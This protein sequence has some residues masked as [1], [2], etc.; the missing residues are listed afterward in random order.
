MRFAYLDPPYLGVGYRYLEHHDEALLWDD[1]DAHRQLIAATD[2]DFPDGWALSASSTSLRTLLPMCPP[3]VRIAAWVK[4][5]AAFK[6]NVRVAY[7]WEPVI[8]TRGRLSSR[9]GAT[10]CRDHIAEPMTMRKGLTGAKPDRFCS[11][12]LDQLGFIPGDEVV[13][14]FPGSGAMGRAVAARQGQFLMPAE[15]TS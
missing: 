6:A 4:P 3:G 14:L 5:W 2:A 13:D 9:D 15:T 11:W 10:P 12:V 8:V 7:T 1:P